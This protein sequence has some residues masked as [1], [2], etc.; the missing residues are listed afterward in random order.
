M[1]PIFL[2]LLGEAQALGG[3]LKRAGATVDEGLRIAKAHGE[4]LSK[5]YLDRIKGELLRQSGK[6]REAQAILRETTER[7]LEADA[8]LFALAAAMG[9]ADVQGD[10]G[11][12]SD[13]KEQVRRILGTYTEGLG[14]SFILRAQR[15]AMAER[16]SNKTPASRNRLK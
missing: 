16:L 2:G 14:N 12:G 3:D 10:I 11:T 13:G 1:R 7:C 6:L 5:L 9:L 8:R 4:L 15:T